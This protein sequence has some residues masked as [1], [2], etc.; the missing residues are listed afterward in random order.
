MAEISQLRLRWH[1]PLHS[2]AVPTEWRAQGRVTGLS[3]AALLREHVRPD[4]PMAIVTGDTTPE[5]MAAVRDA[6]LVLLHKPAH[7]QA[8]QAFVATTRSSPRR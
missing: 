2:D 1:G 4:L 8:V 7:A 5:V 3:V 6:R